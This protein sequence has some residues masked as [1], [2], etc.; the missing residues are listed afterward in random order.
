MPT[1]C[2]LASVVTCL[3]GQQV[4][5]PAPLPK[6]AAARRVPIQLQGADAE[7]RLALHQVAAACRLPAREALPPAPVDWRTKSEPPYSYPEAKAG[8]PADQTAIARFAEAAAIGAVGSEAVLA[9]A[10]ASPRHDVSHRAVLGVLRSWQRQ[11]TW[12]EH[13]CDLLVALIDHPDDDV[14]AVACGLLGMQLRAGFTQPLPELVL[15]A[16]AAWPADATE[17]RPAIAPAPHRLIA[18]HS[19]SG[20]RDSR[21]VL[22]AMHSGSAQLIDRVVQPLPAGANHAQIGTHA[23]FILLCCAIAAPR[24]DGATARR[25]H[26]WYMPHVQ[27]WDPG[28]TDLVSWN[29]GVLTALTHIHPQLPAEL[30][31]SYAPLRDRPRLAKFIR[32][33][34]GGLRSPE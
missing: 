16:N 24:V 17:F 12:N 8:Q 5:A 15:R 25:I 23:E 30:L 28:C 3:P 7:R 31:P 29:Y 34:L 14:A 27:K 26:S 10:L 4:P 1:L 9:T 33:E 11:P 13:T 32:D 21:L 18:F 19:W 22:L 2:L 20:T 6:A